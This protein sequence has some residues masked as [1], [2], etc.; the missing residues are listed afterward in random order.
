MYPCSLYRRF[1]QALQRNLPRLGAATLSGHGFA[2]IWRV[3]AALGSDLFVNLP[4]VVFLGLYRDAGMIAGPSIRGLTP[5]SIALWPATPTGGGD[6]RL[7]LEQLDPPGEAAWCR[8][9]LNAGAVAKAQLP[10]MARMDDDWLTF[11][12]ID[13]RLVFYASHRPC[14]LA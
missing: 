7:A 10:P 8:P 9:V 3:S 11:G 12:R 13:Q 6:G 5:T 1:A 4:G 14:C 2:T